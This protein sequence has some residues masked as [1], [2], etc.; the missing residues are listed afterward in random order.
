MK[1]VIWTDVF[2]VLVM[3]SGFWVVLARGTALVGGPGQVLELAKNHSRINLM[4]YVKMERKIWQSDGAG[5]SALGEARQW[6]L[7]QEALL[8]PLPKQ[9]T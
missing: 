6:R 3:L 8:A 5:I 7:P 1:A 9:K 4:E 2:Q